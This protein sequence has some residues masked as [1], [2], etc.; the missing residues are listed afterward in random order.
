VST[1]VRLSSTPFSVSR[2]VE[3]VTAVVVGDDPAALAPATKIGHSNSA[4]K[5]VDLPIFRMGLV[6]VVRGGVVGVGCGWEQA[7]GKAK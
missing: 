6:W 4:F 1:T 5:K 3:R 7:E 2:T